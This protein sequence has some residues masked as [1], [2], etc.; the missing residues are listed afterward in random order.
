MRCRPQRGRL[1][2]RV[3]VL[4]RLEQVWI[5]RPIWFITTCTSERQ[6]VLHC[7]EVEQILIEEWKSARGRH[8]WCVGSYVIMP[9]HVTSFAPRSRLQRICL[10]SLDLGRNG[11]AKG[12]SAN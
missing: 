11:L 2:K 8:G 7:D 12:W 5:A 1:Q 4:K 10:V 6:T 9:D 3:R